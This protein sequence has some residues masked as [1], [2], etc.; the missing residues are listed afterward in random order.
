[1]TYSSAAFMG[2]PWDI[3]I[4]EYR[5]ELSKDSF[6][7]LK[8]YVKDFIAFLHNRHFFCDVQT[9]CDYLMLQLD[10]FLRNCREE[11]SF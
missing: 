10:L 7:K 6:D 3:I 8:G 11:L 4:K 2:V 9:Q 1:M 5:K